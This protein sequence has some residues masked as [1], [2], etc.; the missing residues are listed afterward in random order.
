VKLDDRKLEN[1][2]FHDQTL[3]K[4][5]ES[6]PYQLMSCS[7]SIP[8]SCPRCTTSLN[9]EMCRNDRC[10]IADGIPRGFLSINFQ[11]PGPK[12]DVCKNDIVVVDLNNQAEGL[13]S[14]IHWH[15]IR[16]HG[17]Q[18]SCTFRVISEIIDKYFT[19]FQ[20]H[21]R[22]SLSD[23]MSRP[24]WRVISLQLQGRR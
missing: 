12:I 14:T 11:L 4:L 18:V 22:R 10:V 15:G 5:D 20:V 23:T 6:Q 1:R 2:K 17:T 3:K 21:G 7:F 19:I 24:I 9:V 13:S 16:Q 8:R